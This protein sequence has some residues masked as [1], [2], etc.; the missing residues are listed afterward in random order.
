MCLWS[1]WS[2]AETSFCRDIDTTTIQDGLIIE[3]QSFLN[4][5]IC[6]LASS[7]VRSSAISLSTMTIWNLTQ[8]LPRHLIPM[9]MTVSRVVID[10]QVTLAVRKLAFPALTRSLQCLFHPDS[11]QVELPNRGTTEL[12]S[13]AA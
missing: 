12:S 6:A 3:S 11:Y 7:S 13:S 1:H 5:L 10:T 8:F 4:S 9:D 2:D